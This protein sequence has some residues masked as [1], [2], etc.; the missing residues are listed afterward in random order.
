MNCLDSNERTA[1]VRMGRNDPRSVETPQTTP[2]HPKTPQTTNLPPQTT[3]IRPQKY[4]TCF[5]LKDLCSYNDIIISHDH[6]MKFIND[7]IYPKPPQYDLKNTRHPQTTSILHFRKIVNIFIL[8]R[9][10]RQC[11]K[12]IYGL[13]SSAK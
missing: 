6:F 5:F 11:L 8:L 9:S 10:H 2:K 1:R 3:T 13:F 7:Q 12:F 4:L